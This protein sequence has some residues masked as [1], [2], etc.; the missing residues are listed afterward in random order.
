MAVQITIDDVTEEVQDK[1]ARMAVLKDQSLKEFL[2]YELERTASR[3][4]TDQWLRDV[5]RRKNA[6]GTRISAAEIL[7]ARDEARG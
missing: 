7:R 4:S 1:L 3:T 6:T 5:R 2:R